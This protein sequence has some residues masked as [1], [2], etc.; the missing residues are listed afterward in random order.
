MLWISIG[1]AFLIGAFSPWKLTE[2]GFWVV[3]VPLSFMW[4]QTV[5]RF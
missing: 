1:G 5:G 3:T 4:G 2:P